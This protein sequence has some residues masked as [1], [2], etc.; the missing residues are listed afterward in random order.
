MNEF[1]KQLPLVTVVTVTY[2]AQSYLEQ[3]IKSVLAQ[4]YSRVEYIVIDGKS[5]DGTIDIIK[6]YE[7]DID[8]WISEKDGGI[9]DAMNKAIDQANGKWINF[10]NAG[11][12]FVD[13]NVLSEIS[14][15]LIESNDLV[16]GNI[17]RGDSERY[18][19]RPLGLKNVHD[20][21]FVFHQALFAKM[22]IMKSSKF[23]PTYK[24]AGDYDF[25]L[26]C[27]HQ[28]YR[29]EFVEIDV[30]NYMEGGLSQ[31]DSFFVHLEVM[32]IQSKYTKESKELCKYGF[33][34]RFTLL[35]EENNGIYKKLNDKFYKELE[36]LLKNKKFI[37]YG[38]GT[39]GK[40]IYSKYKESIICIV[41]KDADK[42]NSLY[43]DINIYNPNQ[44]DGLKSEFILISSLGYEDVIMNELS[45]N[46]NVSLE[47]ILR[48]KL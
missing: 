19:A 7:N 25:V 43:K 2:N 16:C 44:I 27:Y 39:I 33:Y 11:D 23:N 13:N 21:M 8:F 26:K 36:K 17:I 28:G 48:L 9:Y 1:N 6:K 46:Y 4:N 5:T 10:L 37:L 30:V 38:F 32:Y 3:T 24:I 40:D 14:K 15:Y 29:F 20:A 45:N 35:G 41:D 42:L 22:S 34:Q 12:T 47:R 18:R 31:S